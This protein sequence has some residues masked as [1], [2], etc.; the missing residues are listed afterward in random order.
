M[1]CTSL[2]GMINW[3]CF[4]RCFP[5]ERLPYAD[6]LIEPVM[7][8]FPARHHSYPASYN[9][10][11]SKPPGLHPKLQLSIAPAQSLKEPDNECTLNAYFTLPRGL[12]IDE[13]QL[14]P[15]NPQLLESLNIKRILGI[16]GKTDLEAPMWASKRWGSS[17]LVEVDTARSSGGLNVELP[18]HLR[19]LEPE[20][21]TTSS[22]VVF[23]MP[24]VFWAC[25]S[26]EWSKMGSSPFDRL[27]L[28]WEQLFPEQTMY[29]HLSPSEDAWKSVPVPVLNLQHAVLVKI[30]TVVVI[31]GGFL[32]VIWKICAAYVG[33]RRAD[34]AGEKKTQ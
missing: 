6:F 18:L 33:G 32:W 1:F 29:Y 4:G 25:K 24:A 2:E 31:L 3:V 26:E 20:H 5:D 17:V 21:N 27:H 8:T 10:T 7:F 34:G 15:T 28:G 19:Y 12:F 14:S 30:G 22:E 16:S 9:L 13:Y 11:T 23:A